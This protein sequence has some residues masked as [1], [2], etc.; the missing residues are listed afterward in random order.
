MSDKNK[1]VSVSA[2]PSYKKLEN[3]CYRLYIENQ[4][5]RKEGAKSAIRDVLL[6]LVKWAGRIGCVVFGGYYVNQVF[7]A[8]AGK[9]TTAAYSLFAGWGADDTLWIVAC[10]LCLLYAGF[11]KAVGR[12]ES[13]V[14]KETIRELSSYRGKYELLKDPGRTSSDL[15]PTG[16]DP[17]GED[18]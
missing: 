7:T 5:L 8:H 16:E 12:A 9:N 6:A 18:E 3:Q 13:K 2:K 14:H 10:V 15:S 1:R 11:T 17:N 4:V